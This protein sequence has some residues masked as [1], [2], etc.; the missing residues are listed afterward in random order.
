MDIFNQKAIQPMLIKEQLEPF[1]SDD[2]LYEL[3]LDGIRCIAYLD[4]ETDLR[5]KRD[6]KLLSKFPELSCIQKQAKERCILDGELI[7]FKNGVPD[8]YELQRRTIMT[9]KFKIQL[10][11]SKSPAT[12]VAYDILYY[13]NQ[14]ITSLPLLER[15]EILNSIIIENKLIAI[16]RYIAYNGIELFNATVDQKLEGVVAKKKDSIYYYGKRT[17][18][19]VKF[20]RI[21]DDDFIICGLVRKKPMNSLLLGKYKENRIVYQGSVSFGVRYDLLKEYNFKEQPYSPFGFSTSEES[22]GVVTWFEPKLVC[23]VKYMPNT[24]GS[25]RQPVFKGI[26]ADVLPEECKIS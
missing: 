25:L 5:T 20:K 26:R 17:K 7:V 2:W 16:S 13:K 4:E 9:N 1:N 8:F 6:I 24:K 11:V 3:K 10:A 21:D 15:K 18:D 14:E 12:F 22:S 19:W 23:S